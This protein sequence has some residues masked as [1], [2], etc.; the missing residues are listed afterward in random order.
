MVKPA[1]HFGS[2]PLQGRWIWLR[3][4]EADLGEHLS[5][6]PVVAVLGDQPLGVERTDGYTQ[7][8]SR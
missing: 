4:C 1:D 6:V 5:H 8:S 7:R 2:P 3:W